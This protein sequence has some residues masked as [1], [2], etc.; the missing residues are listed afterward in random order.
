MSDESPLPQPRQRAHHQSLT[1]QDQEIQMSLRVQEATDVTKSPNPDTEA[2]FRL[3]NGLAGYRPLVVTC[4]LADLPNVVRRAFD[5]SGQLGVEV[6]VAGDGSA[7][8][9][10]NPDGTPGF[11]L[12]VAAEAHTA[13]CSRCGATR[14]AAG[15]C[16]SSHGRRLCHLCYRRTHW[17]EVC[18]AG[19]PDC[20]SEGLPVC[21]SDLAAQGGETR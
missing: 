4:A 20:A 12:A 18:V 6:E 2:T 17:V 11:T 9:V 8:T 13:A 3:T 16:C 5:P 1:R 7:A 15:E 21:L 10:M 19:C 14:A